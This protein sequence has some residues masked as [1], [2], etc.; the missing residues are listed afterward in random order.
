[1]S[2]NRTDAGVWRRRQ[3]SRAQ[4]K[5]SRI[6]IESSNNLR[7]TPRG[8]RGYRALCSGPPQ[9]R[10]PSARTCAAKSSS[11]WKR[12]DQKLAAPIKAWHI[13][14]VSVILVDTKT[15]SSGSFLQAP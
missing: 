11:I 2:R 12:K 5:L 13:E 1:L 3:P 9:L 8:L 4:Q 14:G 15:T 6:P 7:A 10:H